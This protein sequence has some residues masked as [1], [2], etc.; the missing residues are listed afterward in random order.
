MQRFF[1][2]LLC[3]CLLPFTAFYAQAQTDVNNFFR[4]EDGAEPRVFYGGFT[5]GMNASQV[6]GDGF[7]GYHKAGLNL[8]PLVFA[9][10]TNHFGASMEMI[11]TQKGSRQRG[12]TDDPTGS[13]LSEANDYDLKMNYIEVPVLLR[14]FSDKKI[15]AGAGISYA[16]LI[17]YK[18]EAITVAPVNLD[19]N[20]YPFHK[21]DV[22]VVADV[23]WGLKGWYFGIRYAYSLASIR[24]GDR[25][26]QGYGGGRFSGE[27]HNL[28][29]LR[30]TYLFHKGDSNE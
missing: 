27:Y 29:T 17:N 15:V 14:Y 16:R 22:D 13:G 28:F 4:V 21:S 19:P 26:P 12:I 1:R 5:V 30:L 24:D 2:L 11:Y 7:S 6:D 23:N 18:E 10:F 8:G 20:L 9:R 3:T 25:I